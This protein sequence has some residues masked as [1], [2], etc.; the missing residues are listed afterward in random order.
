[1]PWEWQMEHKIVAL[2]EQA[3]TVNEP[4]LPAVPHIVHCTESIAPRKTRHTA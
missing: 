4:G 3:H 2:Q 1:M